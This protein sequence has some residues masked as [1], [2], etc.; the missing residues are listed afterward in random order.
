MKNKL[1]LFFLCLFSLGFA[2]KFEV[3]LLIDNIY[4]DRESFNIILGKFS[5]LPLIEEDYFKIKMIAASGVESKIKHYDDENRNECDIILMAGVKCDPCHRLGLEKKTPE[6]VKVFVQTTNNVSGTCDLKVDD[7][8]AFSEEEDLAAIIKEQR[9]IAKKK[10]KDYK[11]IFW[12][13]S[14][15]KNTIDLV[16]TPS[17]NAVDFGTVVNVK[18]T[19]NSKEGIMVEMKVNDELIK[20]CSENDGFT[21]ITQ[22]LPLVENIEIIEPTT[23]TVAEK[24]CENPKRIEIKLNST[25]D[26]VIKIKHKILYDSKSYGPLGTTTKNILDGLNT[27]TIKLVNDNYYVILN[28]QCGIRSYAVELIEIQTGSEYK[29]PLMKSVDQSSIHL[30]EVDLEKYNV[31]RMEYN[32]FKEMGILKSRSDGSEPKYKMRIVPEKPAKEG[33]ELEER[34]KSDWVVVKFQKC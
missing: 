19:T 30:R 2:Q 22:Q 28:K 8:E 33:L 16:A 27:T 11:V 14:N 7:Y 9:K 32:T 31:F 29:V 17:D 21:K 18:A 20:K 12:I 4:E 23:V 10:K 1:L 34:H 13:P 24:G 3:V 25:C 26:S 5:L 6:T 15:E